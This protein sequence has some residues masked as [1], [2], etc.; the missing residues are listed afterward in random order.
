MKDIIE[1]NL[2]DQYIPGYTRLPL[3]TREAFENTEAGLAFRTLIEEIES[4]DQSQP[5]YFNFDNVSLFV[6]SML[7]E[8][9]TPERTKLKKWQAYLEA[10]ENDLDFKN[11]HLEINL[12]PYQTNFPELIEPLDLKGKYD[13]MNAGFSQSLFEDG[14]EILTKAQIEDVQ[15]S[16]LTF[17]EYD[18]IKK[19]SENR[20][21]AKVLQ[22][23]ALLDNKFQQL[24]AVFPLI[25]YR[26]QGEKE[27]KLEMLRHEDLSLESFKDKAAEV[28]TGILEHLFQE[29]NRMLPFIRLDDFNKEIATF[30]GQTI[31]DFNSFKN[32]VITQEFIVTFYEQEL[33]EYMM[34]SLKSINDRAWAPRDIP[35]TEQAYST[36]YQMLLK[37]SMVENAKEYLDKLGQAHAFMQATTFASQTDN[38]F[39]ID[40]WNLIRNQEDLNK[41][42]NLLLQLFKPYMPIYLEY[43]NIAQYENNSFWIAYRSLM[44]ILI[45]AAVVVLF[46]VALAPLA[47]PELVM[48]LTMIPA[49]MIGLT[50]AS[51]Y[52]HMKDNL[53]HHAR[54][55]YYGGAYEIP[56]FQ[57]T[58]KMKSDL[59]SDQVAQDIRDYYVE[60]LQNYDK[61]EKDFEDKVS[62]TSTDKAKR[63]EYRKERAIISLEWLD[64]S[65]GD[66]GSDEVS[67]I[68]LNRLQI[69]GDAIHDKLMKRLKKDEASIQNAAHDIAEEINKNLDNHDGLPKKRKGKAPCILLNFKGSFFNAPKSM[70]HKQSLEDIDHLIQQLP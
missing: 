12:I 14:T 37:N 64:I 28:L 43:K 61:L 49:F 20:R 23:K 53:Y 39:M 42:K 59:G 48:G 27:S 69:H 65:K 26:Q 8:V 34:K 41:S 40:F 9:E 25:T 36:I 70:A 6:Y 31:L 24:A 60:L 38:G 19:E 7:F 17:S 67:A 2:E 3:A 58:E 62:L 30:L 66:L 56:E 47:L 32:K 52:I 55:W 18:R 35:M 29:A 21:Q 68:I 46:A 44:P 13:F 1:I 10:Y 50:F 4:L 63:L 45:T 15:T 51:L 16:L 5:S 33:F 54:I 57:V 11:I 22:D